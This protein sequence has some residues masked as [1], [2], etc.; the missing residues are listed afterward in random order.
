MVRNRHKI[1]VAGGDI[2][3]PITSFQ[4]LAERY[5]VHSQLIGN[6]SQAGYLVPTPVQVQALPVMIDVCFHPV[7]CFCFT[8]F[9]CT[10]CTLAIVVNFRYRANYYVRQTVLIWTL[11]WL[12]YS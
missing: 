9:I 10:H 6:I 8:C 11:S 2:A 12:F 3:D 4:E 5:E 1:H 7:W